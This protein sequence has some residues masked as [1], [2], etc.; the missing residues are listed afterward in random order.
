MSDVVWLDA[1][2]KTLVY[3]KGDYDSFEALHETQQAT[4]VPRTLLLVP[5]YA[6]S[7]AATVPK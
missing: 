6:G 7:T 5:P 1:V 2:D 4:Q 3:Y